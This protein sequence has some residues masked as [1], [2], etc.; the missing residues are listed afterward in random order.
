M[1][2]LPTLKPKKRY[3]AFEIISDKQFTA[4]LVELAVM[5]AIKE[6]IGQLGVAKAAPLFVAEQFK[7]N[8]FVLKVNHKFTNETRAALM[9]LKEINNSKVIIKSIVTS[10]IL[11]K[12]SE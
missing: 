8:R 12:V 10:G 5:Q 11:K 2:L 1:K 7:E 3:I 6:F 9:L 4:D